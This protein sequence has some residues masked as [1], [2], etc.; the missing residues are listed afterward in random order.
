MSYRTAKTS[1][2]F[3]LRGGASSEPLGLTVHPDPQELQFARRDYP[4]FLAEYGFSDELL[5]GIVADMGDHRELPEQFRSRLDTGP[6]Q[7]EGQG[8]FATVSIKA[9]ADV[10]P[11]RLSGGRTLAG[12]RVN[13][14]PTPNC[15]FAL[16]PGDD[17]MLVAR[18]DI[19]PGDELTMDYRQA[20]AVNGWHPAINLHETAA[21]AQARG[22]AIPCGPWAAFAEMSPA[23]AAEQV[24]C[25]LLEWGYLPSVDDHHK[26]AKGLR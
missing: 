22:R 21:T 12:R 13:H 5:R 9:G 26:L 23:D 7:I 1:A 16:A 20:G 6:S 24:A 17:L 2:A 10:A 3:T 11:A 25:M 8:V 15:R 4:R 14:S 18:Y 19:A